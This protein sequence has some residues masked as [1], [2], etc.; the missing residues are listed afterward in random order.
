MPGGD[1]TGPN[2]YGPMTGRS[3]GLCAGFRMPGYANPG[4]RGRGMDN[5]AYDHCGSYGRG[6][7]YRNQYYATG[8]PGWMRNVGSQSFSSMTKEE[9]LQ[10]LKD[11]ADYLKNAMNDIISR[12]KDLESD[13]K[14][15]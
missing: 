13:D 10:S 8:M 9:E 5:R 4:G 1:G 2:S 7:G 12:I 11:Q 3:V 15:P 14:K 6:R